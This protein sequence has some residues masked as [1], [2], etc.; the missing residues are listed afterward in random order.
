MLDLRWRMMSGSFGL[1]PSSRSYSTSARP[2][3]RPAANSCSISSYDLIVPANIE[4]A[5]QALFYWRHPNKLNVA[6]I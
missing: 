1:A 2:S 6:P 4:S 3:P 5:L